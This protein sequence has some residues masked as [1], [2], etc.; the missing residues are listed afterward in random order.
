MVSKLLP[1][2]FSFKHVVFFAIADS[3]TRNGCDCEDNPSLLHPDSTREL[4]QLRRL[5]LHLKE[6]ALHAWTYSTQADQ[7]LLL[8]H[9]LHICDRGSHGCLATL[10]PYLPRKQTLSYGDEFCLL[11]LPRQLYLPSRH[12]QEQ[13]LLLDDLDSASARRRGDRCH[14][15]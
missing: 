9:A 11:P 2:F 4:F 13:G 7:V 5:Q 12:K 8:H 15:E 6:F 3:F 14:I 1:R 10:L